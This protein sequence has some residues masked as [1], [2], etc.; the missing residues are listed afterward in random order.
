MVEAPMRQEMRERW[1]LEGDTKLFNSD[2]CLTMCCPACTLVQE[3]KEVIYRTS[4][5]QSK[6]YVAQPPMQPPI[7]MDAQH[8]GQYR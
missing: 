1:G 5:A 2:L 7:Q 8:Q 6:G 4:G 3:E